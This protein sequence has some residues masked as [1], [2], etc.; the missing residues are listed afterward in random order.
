MSAQVLGGG[1][2]SEHVY[3]CHCPSVLNGLRVLFGRLRL[4]RRRGGLVN[5]CLS[6]TRSVV[7]RSQ[8]GQVGGGEKAVLWICRISCV[9][10]RARAQLNYNRAAEI[11]A[12][13][14]HA[15]IT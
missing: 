1:G 9:R 5:V 13:F 14:D 11:S 10:A 15:R 7:E 3:C 6:S 2:C 8:T 12:R 4:L